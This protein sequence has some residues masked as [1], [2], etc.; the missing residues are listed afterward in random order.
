MTIKKGFLAND[1]SLYGDNAYL[2]WEWQYKYREQ[3]DWFNCDRQPSWKK[4]LN[5]R[6]KQSAALPFDLDR[7]INGDKVES[8]W[9]DG[10]WRGYSSPFTTESYI[11]GDEVHHGNGIDFIYM[12][13]I[14]MKYPPKIENFD[15]ASRDE[16]LKA[17]ADRAEQK[18]LEAIAKRREQRRQEKEMYGGR[19]MSNEQA[20]QEQDEEVLYFVCVIIFIISA[21]AVFVGAL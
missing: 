4:T 18:R 15:G 10:E 17:A 13:S 21:V 14:R 5:Y 1:V 12:S 8:L 3:R 16:E 11:K 19:L 9:T 2:M 7:A 6:R 20:A